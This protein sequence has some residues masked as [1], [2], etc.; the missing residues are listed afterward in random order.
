[1]TSLQ[2][3]ALSMVGVIMLGAMWFWVVS[4]FE[5]SKKNV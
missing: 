1:M 2:M 4:L 3:I 5:E